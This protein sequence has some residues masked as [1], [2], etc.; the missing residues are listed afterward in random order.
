MF[1][2]LLITQSILIP[3]LFVDAPS[4]HATP[5]HFFIPRLPLFNEARDLGPLAPSEV[6]YERL[7]EP[8]AQLPIIP[9]QAWGLR[10]EQDWLVSLTQ[11]PGWGMLEIIQVHSPSGEP[12]WFTLDSRLDG[13]Q[14]VGLPSTHP[15]ARA[16]AA[17][18]P[19]TVY[20]SNLQVKTWSH[21]GR[22]SIQVRY[23]RIDGATIQ[24]QMSTQKEAPPRLLR[25]GHGMNHSERDV[26]AVI[27]LESFQLADSPVTFGADPVAP[28][29]K[30]Q[31]I[32]GVQ[33][34]GRLTQTAGG[35][36]RKEW[37]QTESPSDTT[38]YVTLTQLPSG[39]DITPSSRKFQWLLENAQ[40]GL[41][42]SD[43][44]FQKLEYR[45]DIRSFQ[46][47]GKTM[48]AFELREIRVLQ[49][50]QTAIAETLRVRFNPALPDFRYAFETA[51][52]APTRFT[53]AVA[54][55]PAYAKGAVVLERDDSK[56]H[57]TL[58]LKVIS[59]WP[60]WTRNRPLLTQLEKSKAGI[61]AHSQILVPG[62]AQES[63]SSIRARP[64]I[65]ALPSLQGFDF[66]WE[67]RPHRLSSLIVRL[68]GTLS[69]EDP[70]EW[71]LGGGTWA[72]GEAASDTAAAAIT[73]GEIQGGRFFLASTPIF[74]LVQ[75]QRQYSKKAEVEGIHFAEIKLPPLRGN[76]PLS[77]FI[78]G[79]EFRSGP[80]HENTGLTLSGM[81]VEIL[82][83]VE[84]GEGLILK[85]KMNQAFRAVPDRLQDFE[86]YS[87]LGRVHL[88]IVETQNRAPGQEHLFNA[89]NVEPRLFFADKEGLEAHCFEEAQRGLQPFLLSGYQFQ[90]QDFS[91]FGG[92]YIRKIG[93]T[94]LPSDSTERFSNAGEIAR[95]TPWE[96]SKVLLEIPDLSWA[97]QKPLECLRAP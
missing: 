34:A 3:S 73:T 36:F 5:T 52:L 81:G 63:R 48:Q 75:K 69:D 39:Q 61:R 4:A 22:Q 80:L 67:K 78:H 23:T 10:C 92:R 7:G 16:L 88:A 12:L 59:E 54:G 71:R 31:R 94:A 21:G 30:A 2:F 13:T 25:N 47:E 77:A 53:L 58:R 37:L 57:P 82:E 9:F 86:N 62:I 24:F 74:P 45:Y 41:L 85:I 70:G 32:A 19:A 8:S 56:Q 96:F 91:R 51:S 14:Y 76:R 49:S 38:P 43:P 65:G 11:D 26:L 83:S 93:A 90:I 66:A 97:S 46:R 27:D 44:G 33:I 18:F 6:A 20:D 17:S 1:I 60:A 68:P 40:T 55:Q 28:Q 95:E 15:H 35:L 29:R 50:Q 89:R 84:T 72:N 79:F 64:V 87:A 42:V